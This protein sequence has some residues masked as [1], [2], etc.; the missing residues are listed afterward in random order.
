LVTL[1]LANHELGNLYPIAELAAAARAGGA[2]FHTDAVQAVGRVPVDVRGLGV[3]ALTLSAHKLH[4]PKGAGA[5]W[6]RQGLFP[7]PLVAGGH[8]ERERRAG[9]EN[10]PG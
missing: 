1:A 4:G 5:L 10:V 2:V 3:D 9:T 7:E 8:Q 6:V